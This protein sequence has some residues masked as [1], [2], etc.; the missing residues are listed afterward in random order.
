MRFSPRQLNRKSS[1]PLYIQVF[2][3]LRQ[4]VSETAPDSG[5]VL[6]CS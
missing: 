3:I 6:C 2:H 5:T 4:A 1:E